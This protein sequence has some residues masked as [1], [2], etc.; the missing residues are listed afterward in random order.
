MDGWM[1]G[2]T[3]SAGLGVMSG[4]VSQLTAALWSVAAVSISFVPGSEL[5]AS[6]ATAGQPSH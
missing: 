4:S 1:V 2:R 6:V 3:I 5:F